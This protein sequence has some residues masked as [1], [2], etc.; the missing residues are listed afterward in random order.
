M[1]EDKKLKE[2]LAKGALEETSP[3]FTAELMRRI[4]AL[5]QTK[6]TYQPS[7]N[8]KIRLAFITIFATVLSALLAISFFVQPSSLPFRFSIKPA[9]VSAEVF[10]NL[11]CFII[12]FWLLMFLNYYLN[13]R[14]IRD[15]WI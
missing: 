5:P 4:E 15:N 9:F 3:D 10:Y 7:I 12:T 13:K 14:N 6:A 11:V 2:L 8:N 1:Q